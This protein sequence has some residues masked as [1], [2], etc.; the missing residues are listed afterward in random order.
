MA[1]DMGNETT[2]GAD[3]G[4]GGAS[5]VEGGDEQQQQLQDQDQQD[6]RQDSEPGGDPAGIGGGGR[7]NARIQELNTRATTAE[8]TVQLLLERFGQTPGANGAEPKGGW[9]PYEPPQEYG[10]HH[11][12]LGPYVD[13]Y[14]RHMLNP[15]AQAVLD[16]RE[17][18]A[19]LRDEARFYRGGNAKYLDGPQF[20]LIEEARETLSQ[21]LGRPVER[22]D[23][24]N[25]LRGHEKHAH[26]FVTDAER[27]QALD[28]E[29]TDARRRAATVGGRSAAR[30]DRSA[31]PDL[32]SMSP[33]DRIKHFETALKDEP[34]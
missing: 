14:T 5:P 2:T 12:M 9:K 16:A 31:G 26:L 17:Q 8:R 20:K 22:A 27:R 34:V 19:D 7:A 1:E 33:E 13:G 6:Q 4:D 18:L 25:F 11:K 29:N 30:V 32:A 10:D 3:V 24:L 21:R 28:R 15:V 23:V